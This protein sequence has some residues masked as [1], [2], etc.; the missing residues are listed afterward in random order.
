MKLRKYLYTRLITLFK[1]VILLMLFQCPGVLL[2]A[3][4]GIQTDTPDQSAMLEIVSPNKGLLV[5]RVSLT[6]S[7]TNPSPVTSP[8]VG[9]LVFNNGSLQEEGFYYWTGTTWKM[10]KPAGQSDVVGPASSTD[11]AIVRFDGT[12]GKLLQNST[13]LLDDA[14]NV[15]GVNN[16]EVQQFIMPTN[17]IADHVLTS[18]ANGNATWQDATPL[19]IEEDNIVVAPNVSTLNFEGSVNVTNAGNDVAAISVG[20]A[21]SEEQVIQVGS[22]SSF[23]IN[24]DPAV[25]IPWNIEMFK[26]GTSFIHSNSTNPTRIQVLASGTY[27]INYMFSL[28]NTTNQRKTLRSRIRVNGTTYIDRSA[29]YAFTYSS[30][31][32]KATLVSS[33]FLLDLNVNDYVEILVNRQTNIGAVNLVPNENLLFVRIMRTW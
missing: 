14:G 29:C 15:S 20:T 1:A 22:T 28:V 16:I 33:S 2:M 27:E 11:E 32:D 19:D 10:L 26:D 9:L 24:T 18:D 13:I 23:D 30:S 5:P 21:L 3:Q 31:D 17:A 6:A 4:V 12:T 25:A 7:L 8:A